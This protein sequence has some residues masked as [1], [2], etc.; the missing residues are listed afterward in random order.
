MKKKYFAKVHSIQRNMRFNTIF[1]N[2][3]ETMPPC[4]TPL[5]G[6]PIPSISAFS[7]LDII[8]INFLSLIPKVHICLRSF[9]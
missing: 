4:G 6:I 7:I 2:S 8:S 1:D 9:P 5:S 3:V